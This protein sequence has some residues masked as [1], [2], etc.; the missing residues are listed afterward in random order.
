MAWTQADLDSLE[1]AYAGGTLSVRF[2]DGRQ[3]TYP[4]A[5][6]LLS[7]IQTVRA[8]L[9]SATAAGSGPMSRFTSFA[10]D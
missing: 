10:R 3:V 7:R 5:Q 2:A 9:A 1:A 6:D 8:A 4:S